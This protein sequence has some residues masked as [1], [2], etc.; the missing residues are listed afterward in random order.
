MAKYTIG[1]DFGTE[2]GRSVLVDVADGREV[3]TAVYQYSNSVIDEQLPD[4]RR[5]AE[6][7]RRADHVVAFGLA[8]ELVDGEPE[9]FA[10]PQEGLAAEALA[11]A[12]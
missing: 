8:V 11:G 3:A 12:K 7:G 5:H 6:G 10:R 2:S 4:Q 1:V 9:L